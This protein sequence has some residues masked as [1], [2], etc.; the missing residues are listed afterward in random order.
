MRISQILLLFGLIFISGALSKL[1][2]QEKGQL[3]G[4]FTLNSNF[5]LRDTT[6]FLGQIP[7]QYDKQLSSAEAWLYLDYR[8]SGFD[9][10]VRFD[11]FQNSGLINP[12]E[13]YTEQGLGF[14]SISK[15]FGDLEITGGSFYDQI[16]NG[17]L[18][19]AYED[20]N[21][22]LDNAI[23]GARVKYY[24]D[25]RF[26]FMA[27]TG[28]QKR[29]FDYFN[30]I[31]K[32]GYLEGYFPLD[33]AGLVSLYS[34]VGALNRTL[35]DETVQDELI[36]NINLQPLETRF[37]PSYN[38][39]A[40][41]Q[42]NTF[43]FDKIHINTEI[44]YKTEEAILNQ[45]G[46]QLIN[47]DGLF[48]QTAVSYAQPGLGASVQYRYS[49]NFVIRTDPT[50]NNTGNPTQGLITILTPINRQNVKRLPA[51]YNPAA[52]FFGESGFQAEITWSPAKATT[53][54]FNYS[55]VMEDGSSSRLYRE[56]FAKGEQRLNRAWKLGAG[57]QRLLYNQLL[58]EFQ[59]ADEATNSE[60]VETWTPFIEA[61]WRFKPRQSLHF[62]AQYLHT[63][64]DQ[65]SFAWG[66][67]E[68]SLAPQWT[69][70]VG[71][72]INVEPLINGTERQEVDIIH[73]YTASASYTKKQTRLM[74]SFVKQPQG[75]N[76]TGG[77]CRVEPAF[78]GLRLQ[79]ST[80]F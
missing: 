51:R 57:A 34:G 79:M 44:A 18:M 9:F 63:E 10:T 76:C 24:L 21:L 65:G 70:A 28:R 2:A 26:T 5:F 77:V 71:D 33:S 37:T 42:Y 73:Y 14:W 41:N 43:T 72:M 13:A 46:N 1:R 29:R 31:I 52:F 39:Y 19:R 35:D 32:G 11:A 17:V 80:N 47:S 64:Q 75:V 38:V 22:G 12:Q 7:P 4:D 49:D 20:R 74:A 66:L 68:Y 40:F 61:D 62:E 16:G 6:I 8:I 78:S 53:L 36:P 56:Y 50:F 54:T 30:Q 67:L 60:I 69:F 25:D 15:N 59:V 3:S 55:D 48:L 23:Q 58:Y 27:F 45:T